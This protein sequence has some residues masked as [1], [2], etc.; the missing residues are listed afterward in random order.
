MSPVL[1]DISDA[2]PAP[3]TRRTRYILVVESSMQDLFTA[4]MLLQRFS[5]P[6]CTA[7][8]A[9]QALDMVAVAVPSLVITDH[10]LHG[11]SGI[12]L[13][14][15]LGSNSRTFTVPLILL[16]PSGE[17]DLEK[18]G[19]EIGGALVLQKP[20]TVEVL[21]RAV[22]SAMESTPRSN[23]R[24]STALPVSV[25]KVVL[26][27]GK[28]ECATHLSAQG[29]FIRTFKYYRPH[30]TLSLHLTI[31]GETIH[32]EGTILYARRQDDGPFAAPGIAVKFT[33]IT[34]E[35]RDRIRRFIHREVTRGIVIESQQ[36]PGPAQETEA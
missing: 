6:V 22:Q 7:R 1:R 32:V 18:E 36:S 15:V 24:I 5:Y 3:F 2:S 10:D 35:D 21:Y 12:D 4:A 13:L 11:M 25:N 27:A 14:R 16:T 8:T 29:M 33:T 31:G 9:R 20:V 28:G 17:A 23:I 30:E 19:V 26:D 34:G